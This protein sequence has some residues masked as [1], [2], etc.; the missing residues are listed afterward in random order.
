L[1]HGV[2][3]VIARNGLRVAL[4]A[5]MAG[6]IGCDRVTKQIATEVLAGTPARSFL[7]G[8]VRFEYAENPG[9]FLGLGAGW[10]TPVRTTVFALAAL[11]GLAVVTTLSRRLRHTPM[12][13]FGLALFAAGSLSNL[14]DRAA[15]GSVVD[16]L[17]VGLGPVRTGIFNVADVAIF[18]GAALVVAFGRF[19]TRPASPAAH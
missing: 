19:G 3:L 4:L 7:G 9:A 18:A 16:F 14:A 12:A 5:A 13:V 11:G 17:N 8:T 10:P 2:D 6:T 15:Y 1:N